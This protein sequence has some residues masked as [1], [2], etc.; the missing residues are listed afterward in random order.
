MAENDQRPPSS[1]PIRALIALFAGAFTSQG[2]GPGLRVGWDALAIVCLCCGVSL[3]LLSTFWP[4]LT[5]NLINSKLA[6]NAIEL[7]TDAR[8]WAASILIL[9]M[10]V[11]FS[12]L[13]MNLANLGDLEVRIYPQ[14]NIQSNRIA[15]NF[16]DL[17]HPTFFFAFEKTN[18]S[19]TVLLG[20]QA[21]GKNNSDKPINT[22]AGFIK[23]KVT[24]KEF[25]IKFIL[26]GV[27]IDPIDTNGIPPFA[28][29]DVCTQTDAVKIV[30]GVVQ[31]KAQS[32]AEFSQFTFEFD[33]EGN[34]FVRTFTKQETQKQIEMFEEI[35]T[36]DKSSIPR[37]TR[38][39]KG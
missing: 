16:E 24:N 36:P 32:L 10:Y 12:P 27:P 2:L 8:W 17:Q 6:N 20:F 34:K 18:V 7:G 4:P 15:W 9:F 35:S 25:T 39:E 26:Q 33:Y 31:N 22:I 1:G 29:F 19:D 28:E 30:N 23:S 21:H 38:K 5:R 13:L 37:V 11:V 14:G 3:C